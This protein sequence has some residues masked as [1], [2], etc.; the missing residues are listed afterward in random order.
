MV[1]VYDVLMCQSRFVLISLFTSRFPA[2]HRTKNDWLHVLKLNQETK[3]DSY[4]PV[5]W[6]SSRI[7]FPVQSPHV[8]KLPRAINKFPAL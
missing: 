8:D 2:D 5:I 3:K 6:Y 1:S 4:V 7:K